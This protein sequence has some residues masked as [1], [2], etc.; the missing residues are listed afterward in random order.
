[1][2]A[3]QRELL[4]LAFRSACKFPM[5]P[6]HKNRSR[7]QMVAVEAC[8]Q[9]GQPELALGFAN[10]VRDWRRGGIYADYAFCVGKRGDADGARRLIALAEGVAAGERASA[11]S[12][13]WRRDLIAIK[14]ARA[15]SALGERDKAAAAVA[16]VEETSL[17]AVD[18]DVAATAA[19]R[20]SL[21]PPEQAGAEFAAIDSAFLTQS[22]GQQGLSVELLVRLHERFFADAVLRAAIERRFTELFDKLM[23]NLRLGALA[24]LARTNVHNGDLARG[25]ELVKSFRSIMEAHRWRTEDRLPQLA[26]LIELTFLVG[27]ADRARADAKAALAEWHT[28]REGVVDIFRAEA[29]RPLA[30]AFYAIGDAPQGALV[31]ELAIEEG[32]ENPNSRPRCDDLVDTAVALCVRGIEPS[33]KA[34]QRLREISGALGEPW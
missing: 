3:W 16:A 6:H 9:L 10:D 32:Q 24:R 20:I 1:M 4:E 21:L 5:E 30:L 2:A 13:E 17:Q 27:D 8:F 11:S 31:L 34:M 25:K 15:W 14:V 18:A 28:Q 29:L 26:E 23:P 33:A 22:L 7:A 19:E 12:Q